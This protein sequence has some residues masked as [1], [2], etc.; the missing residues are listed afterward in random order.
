MMDPSV[1]VPPILLFLTPIVAIVG[2]VI[3]KFRDS[4]NMRRIEEAMLKQY[5]PEEC[6]L[7]RETI[8]ENRRK[9]FCIVPLRVGLTLVGWGVGMLL[10]VWLSNGDPRLEIKLVPS[11]FTMFAGIGLLSAFL[12]EYRY[13]RKK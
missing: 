9:R 11:L 13:L 10:G 5:S 2:I 4:D 3:Y 1:T 6:R 8:A 7:W 12:I